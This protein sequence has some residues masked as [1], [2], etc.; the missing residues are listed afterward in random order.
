MESKKAV[1]VIKGKKDN[2]GFRKAVIQSSTMGK[3]CRDY[4]ITEYITITNSSTVT[5][6]IRAKVRKLR[7]ENRVPFDYLLI[8]APKE[9]AKTEQ[10]FTTFC[11]QM[12]KECQCIVKWLKN[13]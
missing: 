12:E 13:P 8:Y 4:D 11:W 7:A 10:E 5:K 9:I 6:D 2:P 3:Y 1:L